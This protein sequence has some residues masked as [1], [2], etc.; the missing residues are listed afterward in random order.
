M[1]RIT[2]DAIEQ[3]ALEWMKALG[4]SIEYGPDI[5]FDGSSPERVA[6]TGHALMSMTS[7]ARGSICG[8]DPTHSSCSCSPTAAFLRT[9]TVFF[10]PILSWRPF[11]TSSC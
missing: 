6:E 8:D 5:A 11:R 3:T 10:L 2:E 9:C 4:Y 7:V 1:N